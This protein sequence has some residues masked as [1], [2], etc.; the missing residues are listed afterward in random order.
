MAGAAGGRGNDKPV[1][2]V[3]GQGTAVHGYF[4]GGDVGTFPPAHH[5]VVEHARGFRG[6]SRISIA[7]FQERPAGGDEGAVC[8]G[9]ERL[10]YLILGHGGEKSEFTEI[11]TEQGQGIFSHSPHRTEKGAVAAQ[12]QYRIRAVK[13]LVAS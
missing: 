10:V 5:H 3:G 4:Q 7:A 12:G 9:F 6:F 1:A 11:D 13:Q 2:G 8:Q